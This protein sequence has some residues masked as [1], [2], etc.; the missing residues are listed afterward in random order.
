MTTKTF[1]ECVASLVS[2]IESMYQGS[3]VNPETR[4]VEDFFGNFEF[5]EAGEYSD[6]VRINWP[7]LAISLKAVK[8]TADQNICPTDYMAVWEG[9]LEIKMQSGAADSKLRSKTK[10]F[11]LA[12][13]HLWDRVGTVEMRHIAAKITIDC[14]AAYDKIKDEYSE[15]FD[16]G[17]VPEFLA[18]VD[19]S[20][21]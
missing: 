19:W 2:D 20:Q 6:L 5:E 21:Y 10:A 7:N 13:N 9:M 8:E 4:E 3:E 15:P 14:V 18:K 12:M 17:F 1:L 16:W 11:W